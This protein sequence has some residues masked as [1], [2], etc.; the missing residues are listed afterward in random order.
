MTRFEIEL[1]RSALRRSYRVSAS[2]R[3]GDSMLGKDRATAFY[4]SDGDSLAE[5]STAIGAL[6][7][8]LGMHRVKPGET[9][10]L[11]DVGF[12]TDGVL[13]APLL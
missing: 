1:E 12:V 6:V 13:L 2:M 4:N 8:L 3:T 7:L 10:E 9:R 11:C 5:V